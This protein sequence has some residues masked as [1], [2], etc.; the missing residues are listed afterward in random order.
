[1]MIGHAFHRDLIDDSPAT[2]TEVRF[3]R[4][5]TDQNPVVHLVTDMAQ[6]LP[7]IESQAGRPVDPAAY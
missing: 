2:L 4:T 5:A 3:T 7:L 1:M 6:R